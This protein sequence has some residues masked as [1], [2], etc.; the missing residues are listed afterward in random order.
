MDQDHLVKTQ[1]YSS[2]KDASALKP[3]ELQLSEPTVSMQK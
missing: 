2:S 3:S 1:R